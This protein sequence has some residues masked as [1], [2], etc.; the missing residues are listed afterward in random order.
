MPGAAE[1]NADGAST[2]AVPEVPAPAPEATAAAEAG[3]PAQPAAA[4]PDRPDDLVI[5]EGIGPKIASVLQ[6]AG[7]TTF[8]HLA[9]AEVSRLEQILQAAGL[10]LADPQTW[11]DQ[12]RLAAAGKWDELTALQ[13]SLKGGRRA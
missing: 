2:A 9:S 5:I 3:V 13:D 6:A 1:A 10:R 4:A 8:D 7:I 12:A 11:R